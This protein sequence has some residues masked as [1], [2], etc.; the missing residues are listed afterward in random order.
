MEAQWWVS[1]EFGRKTLLTPSRWNR[2]APKGIV[3]PLW[4]Y[5]S[6][7][8]AKTKNTIQ[9]STQ[10]FTRS[11]PEANIP[12]PVLPCAGDPILAPRLTASVG[13]VMTVWSFSLRPWG[14]YISWLYWFICCLYG[15]KNIIVARARSRNTPFGLH[16]HPP[17]NN[18][19]MAFLWKGIPRLVQ[20]D[21]SREKLG[22]LVLGSAEKKGKGFAQLFGSHQPTFQAICWAWAFFYGD[23]AWKF[24]FVLMTNLD[25]IRRYSC[26]RGEWM[27]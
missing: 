8:T 6:I 16:F 26:Q 15:A 4:K 21:R 24:F 5:F 20:R 3:A 14:R 10:T 7:S 25:E 1:G 9:F 17:L 27:D 12:H 19:L 11:E 18:I 13:T 22:E 23:L 2:I